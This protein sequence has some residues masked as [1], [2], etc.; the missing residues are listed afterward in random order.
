MNL[1]FAP[2]YD[3][4]CLPNCF[5]LHMEM[6]NSEQQSTWEISEFRDDR[7]ELLQWFD[8]LNRT[9]TPM[10][11]F[12]SIHYDYPMIHYLWSNP[13]ASYAELYQKS[14][15]IIS[16]YYDKFS[17][18]IW[19][20]DRFAPQIDLFKVFHFDNKAK[21]TSLKALQI[22]MRLDNVVDAPIE[23]NEPISH[24]MLNGLLVPYNKWDVKSTKQFAHYSKQ[25]LDFRLS[26]VEQFGPDVMNYNDSKIGSKILEQRLGDDLCYDRSTGRRVMRQT[27]RTRI[28][29]NDIIFPYV[30]FE[31][32]EFQ[33][34]LDYLRAQVLTPADI[35][36]T[37]YRVQAV[38]TKG[39]FA[40]L[41]AHVGGIDFKFGTGG[42]H[43]SVE[44][45]RI[46][47]TDEWLIRD[48]DVASLYPSIAIVNR[49]APAHLG[50]RFVD[51]YAMLPKERKEWQAKKGKKCV[52]ANSLK[53][54]GNGTY[55]NSNSMF[56]VFYDPQFTMT[57][58]ING[59]LMLTMLAE[60]LLKVP[61]LT[62][63]QI[64][65]DGITYSIH[66]DYE[67]QAAATCRQWEAL[68]KLTLEDANY[69]RMFIR[70]VNSY[71][72]ESLDGSLKQKGAYWHPDPLR[73]A[74]SITE[75][76]PPAWHKDLGNIVS[77]RA[78]VA[79]MVHNVPPET[80]IAAHT[81]PFDFM[82][83]I[84][85]SRADALHLDGVPIQKTTRYYVARNGGSMVKIS[86]PPK[87][88][89]VGAFKRANGVSDALWKQ[90]NDE[91]AKTGV[92]N[93]WDVRIHTKNKSR[94]EMRETAIE[95][96]YKVSI[97]N[98]INDFRFDNINREWYIQEAKKLII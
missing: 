39:V 77:I 42:I 69:K 56:S 33:R 66:R 62:I 78:A 36:E 97:C 40:G 9:Q 29:L 68:T 82:L 1:E 44:R 85:V 4:E 45:Q 47:A 32:P 34:V 75:A 2:V 35:E 89:T 16:N 3:I 79:A 51:E 13:N 72:A 92:P 12:N 37:E 55:G 59:Q 61:T 58:T 10:I 7:R 49:L 87:G 21:T 14:Q 53:L 95:A 67:P 28:A 65:T 90:V 31:H 98:D 43:G 76:Q 38:Q 15:S 70:D 80:F 27:P 60:W 64:N 46:V 57:I 24:N 54:A 22:N 96:G 30:R 63:I 6:L 74:D 17:H 83:R 91:L 84:K 50:E 86:P 25:A 23:F 18:V 52:E 5:L 81:D 93:A 11:A 48:I 73:Y 71:V 19:E 26:L 8:W 94:Y 20:R 41:K 88:A